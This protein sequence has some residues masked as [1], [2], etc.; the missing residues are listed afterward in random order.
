MQQHQVGH[1]GFG[2]VSASERAAA[3]AFFEDLLGSRTR[4]RAAAPARIGAREDAAEYSRPEDQGAAL[5]ALVPLI[6]AGTQATVDN[7]RRVMK[8]ICLYHGIPW[9]VGFV[10]LEHEGGVNLFVHRDGVMQTIES[11]RRSVMPRIP[12]ELALAL[13]GLPANS[14]TTA[15]DLVTQLLAAFGNQLAIQIAAGV[16]ELVGNLDAMS[17]YVALALVAYNAGRGWAYHIVNRGASQARPAGVTAQRWEELCRAGAMLLH[18]RVGTGPGTVRVDSGW[19]QCDRN[20]PTWFRAYRV[21]D[22]SVNITL[23]AYQYLRRIEARIRETRPTTACD[24]TTHGNREPGTGNEITVTTRWGALDKLYDPSHLR[25][26]YRSVGP[27]DMPAITDDQRP[28]RVH[29]GSLY[30]VPLISTAGPITSHMVDADPLATAMVRND[31]YGPHVGWSTRLN[32]IHTLL[33]FTNMS[34]SAH[35][36]ATAV[37]S[38]QRLAGLPA[39]GDIDGTTWQRMQL[40]IQRGGGQPSPFVLPPTP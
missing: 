12:R 10:V 14:A 4:S 26:E 33:G 29:D 16:Q 35:T 31:L 36:F 23:V 22:D 11:A 2:F 6:G 19:Y 17:G 39:T 1:R 24:A 27:N 9:R 30:K 32:D 13:L 20:I 18:Q 7:A 37:Q 38:W 8:A 15:A 21:R 3:D 5:R 28:L 34:P 40:Q 25:R